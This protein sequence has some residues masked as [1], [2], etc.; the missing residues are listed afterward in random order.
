MRK[1]FE[2]YFF[3]KVGISTKLEV[4]DTNAET[5]DLK[6]VLLQTNFSNFDAVLG[7]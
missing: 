3:D 5:L 7:T 6:T 4:F 1:L 2:K